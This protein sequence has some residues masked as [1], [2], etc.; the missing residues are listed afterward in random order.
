[1]SLPQDAS[2]N[3]LLTSPVAQPADEPSIWTSDYS[4]SRLVINVAAAILV[5]AAFF[6]ALLPITTIYLWDE[7]VY[8]SDAENLLAANPYY[9]EAY[10]RPPLMRVLLWAGSAIMPIELFAHVLTAA[11]FAL[12]VAVLYLFGSILYGRAAGLVA[13]MLMFVSSFFVHWA[14]K[15]MTD[16]P[17]TVLAVASFYFVWRHLEGLRGRHWNLVAGGVLM[18][19]AVLMRFPVAL[20]IIVPVALVFMRRLSLTGAAW[21]GG[22]FALSLA[23][24][25]AWA[26]LE[27]GDYMQPLRVAAEI[28]AGSEP[29]ADPLYYLKAT[30]I[31]GGPV[32]LFGL[33]V[34]FYV[35]TGRKWSEWIGADLPLFVWYAA[36]TLYLTWGSHKELRYIIPVMPALFLLA[37]RGLAAVKVRR[38]AIGIALV[39]IVLALYPLKR[40]AWF[41]GTMD[42][43]EEILLQYAADTRTQSNFIRSALRPG[44]VIYS[45]AY[46]PVIA[47]YTKR[48]TVALWPWDERFY[49]E[50][51]KNMRRDGLMVYYR[52]IQRDPTEEW[53]DKTPAFRRIASH[54]KMIVYQYR[55]K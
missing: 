44:D 47:F 54:G 3:G 12:G 15:V 29:V 48:E 28:V 17:S 14:G 55:A 43:G 8:L 36:L 13:A 46:Y 41:N 27:F 11:F 53:L 52:N 33:L 25:F 7:A 24:Y 50:Y 22:A 42:I 21:Y 32:T 20:L 40:L 16:I 4:E 18:G 1:L 5:V 9:S 23:P 2:P 37:G 49:A 6:V 34:Y 39:A 10:Y 51:P 26:Q 19:A 45:S 31:V 30:W 35:A 38:E